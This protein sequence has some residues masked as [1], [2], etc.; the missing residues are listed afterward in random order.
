LVQAAQKVKETEQK[1]VLIAV[2]H[3]G[4]STADSLYV[5]YSYN[6]LFTATPQEMTAFRAQTTRIAE[7]TR[8]TTDENWEVYL[9]R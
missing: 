5:E 4:F 8:A 6:R 1:S 7:F 2:G 9:L 3:E